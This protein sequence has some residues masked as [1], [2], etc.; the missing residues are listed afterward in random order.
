MIAWNLVIFLPS[1]MPAF[2]D[3]GLFYGLLV[4]GFF[5]SSASAQ[6]IAP[7]GKLP[8]TTSGPLTLSV[9]DAVSTTIVKEN[10]ASYVAIPGE[11][12]SWKVESNTAD[13]KQ[14]WSIDGKVIPVPEGAPAPTPVVEKKVKFIS[15]G[16]R[17]FL[18]MEIL[19][20]PGENDSDGTGANKAGEEVHFSGTYE[21]NLVEGTWPP[22][23]KSEVA[24]NPER[25]TRVRLAPSEQSRYSAEL[26]QAFFSEE[27][28]KHQADHYREAMIDLIQRKI[29]SPNG[30]SA[31]EIALARQLLGIVRAHP[32]AFVVEVTP[33]FESSPEMFL[34]DASG[35][36]STTE[37]ESW[38]LR[39]SAHLP[40]IAP[41][42]S[43][44]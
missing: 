28:L 23:E 41:P 29:A 31:G 33:E 25:V 13:R 35:L 18:K 5:L 34:F 9:R 24:G 7:R 43:G 11:S 36:H 30:T 6:R 3:R 32:E 38:T 19:A 44:R 17:I 39:F 14:E 4:A 2:S 37:R 8:R 26:Q 27:M 10:R 12:G 21:A 20:R 15:Y 16:G 1:S 42:G 22:T 40:A